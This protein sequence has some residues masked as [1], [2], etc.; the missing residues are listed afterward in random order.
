MKRLFKTFYGIDGNKTDLE[1][2]LNNYKEEKLFL[3]LLWLN[4]LGIII[5]LIS[6]ALFG[7]SF[8]LLWHEKIKFGRE[9]DI[10]SQRKIILILQNISIIIIPLV[11]GVILHELIHGFFYALFAKN[12]FKSI[13]LGIKLKYGVAYCICTELIKVKCSIIV[14]IM[15]AIILGFIPIFFSLVLGNLFLLIFGIIFIAGS[16]GDFLIVLKLMKE[17]GEN[18]ILDTLGEDKYLSIYRKIE[19]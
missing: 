4:I 11:I 8:Y 3:D 19:T 10:T 14:L 7:G 13:K 17:N 15:P 12:K 5:L 9:I 6:S 18:Y 2:D 1:I 16:S